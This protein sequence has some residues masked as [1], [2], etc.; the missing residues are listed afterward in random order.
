[1][2]L[3]RW[4]K[5]GFRFYYGP[6]V[7]PQDANHR[8]VA[9]YDPRQDFAFAKQSG[10]VGLVVWNSPFGA[11]TA[12]GI[13]DFNSRE[14]VFKA[15]RQL[16][17]PMGVNIGLEAN[18][19]SLANRYPNDMTPNARAVPGRLVRGDQFR[20]R[21]H[22]GLE[23][24]RRAGRGPG[25]TPAA[26]PP[27]QRRRYGGQLAGTARRNVPRRLRRARRPWAQRAA[28]F[29]SL[30]QDQ[31]QDAR[32]GGRPL[33]T[34]GGLQDMGGRSLSRIRHV[35]GLERDG[36]R[37]DGPLE[38][39]LR[40]ALRRPVG[41]D[42]S[43]RLG[44]GERPGAGPCHRAGPAAQAGRL[45]PAHQD[46]SGLAGGASAGLA[47][48]AGSERHPRR[49]ADEPRP[50]VR[51]RQGDSR[52]SALPRRIALGHAGGDLRADRRR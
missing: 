27:A 49:D 40:R 22:R 25:A 13:L 11:P 16:N 45:P 23:F 19:P 30:P 18:N 4:D 42:R 14:W 21:R 8:E 41:Q 24:R 1:M 12:D 50:R 48:S 15:A 33:A 28:E 3:D 38:D 35:S 31:V 9:T 47:L 32:S 5:Y 39:Q 7:K 26:G 20:H 6:F 29:L 52:E 43:G 51:Q 37:S 10:D 17:L 34:A 46:R 36:D 2:Y 44:L